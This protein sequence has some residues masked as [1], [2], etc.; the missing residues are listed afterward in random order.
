MIAL[1][2][3]ADP[4]INGPKIENNNVKKNGDGDEELAPAKIAIRNAD[5]LR[6]VIDQ[7]TTETVIR[8]GQWRELYFDTEGRLQAINGPD[9]GKIWLNKKFS[10]DE[11]LDLLRVNINLQKLGW[12][13]IKVPALSET[14]GAIFFPKA[15][16]AVEMTLQ[17]FNQ[18]ANGA[19]KIAESNKLI[20]FGA[21]DWLSILTN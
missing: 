16:A 21:P 20:A 19:Y 3:V 6:S 5:Q 18:L 4:V 13:P 8:G 14:S 1:Q 11:Q 10:D 9:I 17:E 2:S 12:D 7:Y 15:A